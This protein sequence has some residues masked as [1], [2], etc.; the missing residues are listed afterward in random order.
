[1]ALCL[2]PAIFVDMTCD[3]CGTHLCT[4]LCKCSAVLP[5]PDS[6]VVCRSMIAKL[7][8]GVSMLVTCRLFKYMHQ[9]VP[10]G[11]FSL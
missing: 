5:L 7:T 4:H 2:L 1:M 11:I 9:V 10:R 6:T 8:S 3:V